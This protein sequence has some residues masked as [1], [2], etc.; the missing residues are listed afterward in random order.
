MVFFL[1][2]FNRILNDML[3]D[4]LTPVL[5]SNIFSYSLSQLKANFLFLT[6]KNILALDIV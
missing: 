1:L 3:L 4:L 5:R 2:I 6:V